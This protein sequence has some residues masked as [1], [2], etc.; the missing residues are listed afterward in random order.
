MLRAI[1]FR[2]AK[3]PNV[4]WCLAKYCV[5]RVD[6]IPLAIHWASSCVVR[7]GEVSSRQVTSGAVE[8]GKER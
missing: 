7:F 1:L 2:R 8:S 4:P 3:H 6:N 5:E